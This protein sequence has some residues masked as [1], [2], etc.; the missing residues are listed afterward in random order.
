MWDLSDLANPRRSL[1]H[2]GNYNHQAF[3]PDGR[4]VT[5]HESGE[6]AVWDVDAGRLVATASTAELG[7]L[8]LVEEPDQITIAQ[9]RPGIA[10]IATSSDGR[11]VAA[12]TY[13]GAVA[14]FEV[15]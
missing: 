4:L 11:T 15:D 8:K 6:L 10:S 7:Q 5:A 3:L 14:L 9:D 1:H 12:M 13:G 2:P